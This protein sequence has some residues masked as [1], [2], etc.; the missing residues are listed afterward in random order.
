MNYPRSLWEEKKKFYLVEIY[1]H[2]K[3]LSPVISWKINTPGA[4]FGE[5]EWGEG[6][7]WAATRI[8]GLFEGSHWGRWMEIW[9]ASNTILIEVGMGALEG[10]QGKSV[11][12]P[13]SLPPHSKSFLSSAGRHHTL[14]SLTRK[15]DTWALLHF[16][17]QLSLDFIREI[18]SLT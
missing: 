1:I 5:L 14:K 18:S 6:T 8:L 3:L 10:T 4:D 2:P 13:V 11:Y 16:A 7:A 9:F 12:H 15:P 17:K